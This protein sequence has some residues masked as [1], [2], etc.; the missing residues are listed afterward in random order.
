MSLTDAL[1]LDEYRDSKEVWIALRTD[2][3]KGSGTQSDPWNGNARA[4]ATLTINSL[5]RSGL[6]ATANVT[7]HGFAVG[8]WVTI[9]GVD[10]TTIGNRFYVGTFQVA[11]ITPPNVAAQVIRL[12]MQ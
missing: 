8:D 1:L 11:T 12:T 4:T 5:A 9:S 10:Q 3:A 2:G 6:T 7:N